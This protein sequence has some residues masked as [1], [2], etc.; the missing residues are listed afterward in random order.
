MPATRVFDPRAWMPGGPPPWARVA[1]AQH[2]DEMQALRSG[3]RTQR[4]GTVVARGRLDFHLMQLSSP[5]VDVLDISLSA[6]NVIRGYMLEPALHLSGPVGGT[7]RV[8]RQSIEVGSSSPAVVVPAHCEP[9][10]LVPPGRTTVV[11]MQ[12]RL[13]RPELDA[14]VPGGRATLPAMLRLVDLSAHQLSAWGNALARFAAAARPDGD[15]RHLAHVESS[16]ASL[17]VDLLAPQVTSRHD[18]QLS[19]ARLALIEDWIDGH[20]GDPITLGRLCTVAGVGARCLQKSFE[21]RRGLSP[22]RFV[23]E[24]RIVEAHRR[25]SSPDPK[26]SVKAVA[27]DL[28]FHHLG[29]FADYYRQL[30]GESPS[31]TRERARSSTH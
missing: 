12:A 18:G 22:M 16:M 21:S 10:R 26:L 11:A 13:W 20:L 1:T 2:A 17:M 15:L 8:G 3:Y 25:L 5:G 4:A 6:P 29:R 30:L 9:T 31:A 28:G 14:R 19:A 27:L 7:Y 23:I 24:R